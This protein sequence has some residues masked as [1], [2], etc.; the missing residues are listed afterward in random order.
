MFL[1]PL[2]AGAIVLLTLL[3]LVS[4][5]IAVRH[6]M[7]IKNA[8]DFLIA[9]Y[10]GKWYD[11]V[12]SQIAYVVGVATTIVLFPSLAYIYGPIVIPITVIAW[13]VTLGVIKKLIKKSKELNEYLITDYGLPKFIAGN[14]AEG[15]GKTFI[16]YFSSIVIALV[17]WASSDLSL[18]HSK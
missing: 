17:Y 11:F 6:F 14:F 7:K 3:L 5:L 4:T 8:D 16:L 1:E 15:R 12:F 10:R 9:G 13:I 18:L 2:G